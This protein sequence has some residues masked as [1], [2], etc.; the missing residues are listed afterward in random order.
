MSEII[1]PEQQRQSDILELTAGIDLLDRDLEQIYDLHESED[2]DFARDEIQEQI[3]TLKAKIFEKRTFKENSKAL[4]E[5][6]G[7]HAEEYQEFIGMGLPVDEY[8]VAYD[9]FQ[10]EEIHEE[11]LVITRQ[12]IAELSEE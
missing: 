9:V 8:S 12:Q 4:M 2:R 5:Y 3:D 11:Y 10:T 7:E 1:N 6:I